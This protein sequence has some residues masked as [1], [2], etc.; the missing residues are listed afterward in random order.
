MRRILSVWLPNLPLERLRHMEPGAAC[1][2]VPLALTVSQGRRLTIHAVTTRAIAAGIRPGMGLAD[3][4]A[5][6]PA[7]ASRPAELA[8]DAAALRHLARW[9]T[10]YGPAVNT[11]GSDGLWV[12]TTGAAHLFGGERGLLKDLCR[13]FAKFGMTAWPGLGDGLGAASVLARF[14]HAPQ[15]LDARCRDD[16]EKNFDACIAPPGNARAAL[17]VYPVEALRLDA[18]TLQL[19]YRLGLRTIGDAAALPRAALQR[20]F[21]NREVAEAVLLRL[22]QALGR[23]PEPLQ[24]LQ[25]PPEYMARAV[26]P[27]PLISS[28]DLESALAA[29]AD[30]LCSG[31][32]RAQRGALG[33]NLTLYRSNG[34]RT[35]VRVGL[36]RPGRSPWHMLKLFGEKLDRVDAG[37][38]IDVMLLSADMSEPLPPEQ[39]AFGCLDADRGTPLDGEGL[40]ALIDRLSGRLGPR[41]VMRLESHASHLPER[42]ETPMPALTAGLRP[43][44]MPAPAAHRVSAGRTRPPFLL[45]VPEPVTIIAE[46][47]EGPP[48]LLRWRRTV[49]NVV[50][51]QGPERIAPEWWR[52]IGGQPSAARDYY[53]IEDDTGARFWVFRDG[54]YD[55]AEGHG[56]SCSRAPAWYLHGLFG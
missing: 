7:L 49:H 19:L 10:R 5:I 3:A 24:P 44:L 22:D 50:R 46:V 33:F 14:A 11:D 41:H 48:Q 18:A 53:V 9:C 42:A 20:R 4:R 55:Q 6:C 37:F 54:L 36:S 15:N 25:P 8:R 13:R 56:A 12:D 27:D 43:P 47:P 40:A 26:F 1:D 17:S 30:D 34:T 51:A 23:K 32:A 45:P 31:L 28:Q 38:G 21:P 35:G 39:D 29:L 2:E 16:S 52:E